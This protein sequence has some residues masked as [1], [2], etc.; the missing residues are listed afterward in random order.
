MPRQ[1][2]EG[3]D[4]EVI[5]M[6]LVMPRAPGVGPFYCGPLDV[7]GVQREVMQVQCL[8]GEEADDEMAAAA[9]YPNAATLIA[10]MELRFPAYTPQDAFYVLRLDP[11]P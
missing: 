1:S 2:L 6:A 3:A 8:L 7:G 4:Y 5:N 9:G 10:V 11:L